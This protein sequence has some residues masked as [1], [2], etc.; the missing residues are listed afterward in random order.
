ML[1]RST[2]VVDPRQLESSRGVRPQGR[3][4]NQQLH[5]ELAASISDASATPGLQPR[6]SLEGGL[7]DASLDGCFHGLARRF[8]GLVR[9][10]AE[11]ENVGDHTNGPDIGELS[12]G[13]SAEHLG[14][15]EG[16]SAIDA[17]QEL[18]WL[19]R[20]CEP[21]VAE[22]DCDVRSDTKEVVRLHV[23]MNDPQGVNGLQAFEHLAE[24]TLDRVLVEHR[25][26]LQR[27]QECAITLLHHNVGKTALD[28]AVGHRDCML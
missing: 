21:E 22:L 2:I 9:E 16:G 17:A 1:L 20:R 7:R 26:A 5:Q 23:T 19:D 25:H 27:G 15:H 28:V 13:L 24:N 12:V 4:S 6:L 8:S 11:E 10:L 18:A 14:A 3:V